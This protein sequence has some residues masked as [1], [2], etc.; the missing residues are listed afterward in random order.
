MDVSAYRSSF[1]RN[2]KGGTLRYLERSP[3]VH[4][5]ERAICGCTKAVSERPEGEPEQVGQGLEYTTR[6]GK[7]DVTIRLAGDDANFTFR[8]PKEGNN[9]ASI[10]TTTDHAYF[11]YGRPNRLNMEITGTGE[12]L[13]DCTFGVVFQGD[14]VDTSQLL[15]GHMPSKVVD[16]SKLEDKLW[17]YA[18]NWGKEAMA[19][20]PDCEETDVWNMLFSVSRAVKAFAARTLTLDRTVDE[21]RQIAEDDKIV[22]D[23]LLTAIQ[24]M[25]WVIDNLKETVIYKYTQ[26]AYSEAR[27]K[28]DPCT[29]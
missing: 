14:A 11:W 1:F 12:G 25:A 28:D 20:F 7:Y 22:Q 29:P 4:E 8:W 9:P 19:V 27:L 23:G 26:E 21:I 10:Q 17:T 3:H 24:Y 15:N 5:E 18:Y 16:L 2:P 13:V 6:I